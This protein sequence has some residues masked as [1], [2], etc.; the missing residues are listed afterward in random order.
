[1]NTVVITGCSSGFGFQAAQVLAARGDTVF[2]TMR[3]PHGKN[4]GPDGEL[5]AFAKANNA[6]I[7]VLDLDVTSDE[8][9]N[10]AAAAVGKAPD[11]IINNAGQMFVG[12]GEAFTAEEMTRQLDVNVVGIHRVHRAFLPAMRE[13]GKG[14]VINISSIAGR[15]AA[16]FF[17]VYHA[18]KWGVEGYSLGMRRELACTGVDV[19]VVE[20][21]PFS[22]ELFPQSPQPDDVDGRAQTYPQLLHDTFENMNGAFEGMFEDPEVPTE[23]I[24]VV[25]RFI[26]L[27]DMEPGTRPFRSVVGVDLGIIDRN[28]DD[29]S[30][31]G[32]FLEA[33]GLTEFVKL[34]VD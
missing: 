12:V 30:H 29:E 2:A 22:T 7:R 14:L 8:S 17:A 32:P 34:R 10:A 9:V 28:A 5:R 21:G 15:M 20:P 18:S 26:E 25:N 6:D 33:M 13:R 19:V 1:M 4:A 16:P 27:I 3:D 31:D 11:V 23:P 24:A